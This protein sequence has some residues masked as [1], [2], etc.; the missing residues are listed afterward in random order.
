MTR[1]LV[2]SDNMII[3]MGLFLI[4]VKLM[5]TNDSNSFNEAVSCSESNNWLTATQGESMENKDV[6]DLVALLNNSSNWLQMG[7]Q[8]LKGF[9]R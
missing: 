5:T 7:I 3:Y 6:L 4:L 9:Q 1:S 8:D 2:L